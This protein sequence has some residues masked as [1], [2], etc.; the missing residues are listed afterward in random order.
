MGTRPEAIKLA[1]ILLAGTSAHSPRYATDFHGPASRGTR[2]GAWNCSVSKPTSNVDVMGHGQSLARLSAR[3][4]VDLEGALRECRPDVVLVQGDTTS[5]AMAGL[6]AFY[7]HIPVW[8]VEAGL[9]T[10][11]P[12]MPFPEEMNRR[13]LARLASFNL[14]PTAR[15]RKTFFAKACTRMRSPSPEIQESMRYT[16]PLRLRQQ[17]SDPF[18]RRLPPKRDRSSSS[19]HTVARTGARAF[20]AWP[21]HARSLLDTFA[22]LRVIHAAHPNPSVRADVEAELADHPGAVIVGSG[23]LR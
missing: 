16:R 1:P 9:R 4:L 10:S 7:A 8:H 21:Q 19:R 15:A 14:A 13:L 6:A 22:D 5:A 18:W 2:P 11:T 12:D 23:R 3:C 17:F 20:A